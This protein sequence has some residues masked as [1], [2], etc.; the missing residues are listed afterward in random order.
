M[1][2]DQDFKRLVRAR[3][4]KT[5]ESY[6]AARRQLTAPSQ[7]QFV[8]RITSLWPATTSGNVRRETTGLAFGCLIDRGTVRPGMRVRVMLHGEVVHEGVVVSLRAGRREVEAVEGG[9]LPGGFGL[10]VEPPY[11]D[12]SRIPDTVAG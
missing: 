4:A 3:A 12:R 5:G 7:S 1:T 8:A 9:D 6:Q 2:E 11:T 10:L